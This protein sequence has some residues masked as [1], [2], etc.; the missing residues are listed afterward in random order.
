MV[1]CKYQLGVL[2]NCLSL[3]KS[4]QDDH[5][6]NRYENK[7]NRYSIQFPKNWQFKESD[8][9]TILFRGKSGTPAYYSTVNIQ[10]I[11]PKKSG[12]QFS[13]AD[14]LMDSLTNQIVSAPTGGKILDQGDIDLPL[15]P[16]R[17]HGRYV[18]FTYQ[19]KGESFKQMQVVIARDDEKAFYAW[20]YTSPEKQ[21]DTYLPIG[22]SLFESWTI[23]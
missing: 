7:G 9:G 1:P 23:D 4:L 16:K 17:F 5:S 22:K 15:N 13:T 11:L 6:M 2:L 8:K 14:E 12:G 10:T 18:I 20:A 3:Y 21:Y 19:Y